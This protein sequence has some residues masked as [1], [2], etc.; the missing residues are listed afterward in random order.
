[1]ASRSM[2]QAAAPPTSSAAPTSRSTTPRSTFASTIWR[3][4]GGSAS[5]GDIVTSDGPST[6]ELLAAYGENDL[7]RQQIPLG[8]GT[9]KVRGSGIPAGHTVW[10]AGRQIPVDPQGNFAAEEILPVGTHSV[11]VGVL[12]DAGNGSLY[13]RDLELKRTDL[14]YVGIADLTVSKNSASASAK[15][16]EGENAR[17]PYD[18]SLDGRL[19]FYLNGKVRQDWRLTA[20][21]DTRE[22]PVKDLFS[23][24]LGKSP[25]SLFR[26]IDPD[27][28]YPSFGDDGVVQEMAPTLGKFYAKASHGENYGMWGNFKVGYL[29][30]ELAHV[31]RGL[32]GANAHYG[33]ELITSFGE[34]RVAVDGFAAQPGTMASYEEFRGTGGSL[35]FLHHQDI[36]T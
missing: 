7:T 16:Q 32:Y 14:F 22:G 35:Y 17:Q 20:S 31:D 34:R 1:M 33:S 15:L 8:S 2:T 6:R 30:N 11:E 23:N 10:V 5:P 25:D 3:R 28:Y 12:D 4:G 9:V 29:D 19:A 27:Y 21:A 36:L 26:R 18:S 13:L 24:F